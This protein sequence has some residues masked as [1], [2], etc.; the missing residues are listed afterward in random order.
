METNWWQKQSNW[1]E[2]TA[3]QKHAI[4]GL[5]S[6]LDLNG[7]GTAFLDHNY[8]K[9]KTRKVQTKKPIM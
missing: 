2:I 3:P 7:N 4:V 8:H 1:K 9:K 6:K 5:V